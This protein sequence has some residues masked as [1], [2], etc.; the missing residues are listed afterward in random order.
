M[1]TGLL[2]IIAMGIVI[3]FTTTIVHAQCLVNEDWSDTP[4]LDDIINGRFNQD[5]VNKWAEYYSYKGTVFMEEKHSELEHVINEGNLQNWVDESDQNRNVYEYYFFSGRAPNL[6]GYSFGFD[7][8]MIDE[9]STIHDP[10]TDDERYQLTSTKIPLGGTGIEFDEMMGISLISY[11]HQW[12]LKITV[13]VLIL[14]A[15]S[16]GTVVS[17]KFW[18][19]RA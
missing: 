18:R 9:S 12:I 8:F 15:I 2:I 16:V 19:K 3:L 13:F 7:E 10:Y 14:I 6:V 11:G 5:Q 1:K 4:C 17:I